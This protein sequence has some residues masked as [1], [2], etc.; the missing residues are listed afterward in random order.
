MEFVKDCPL[1]G[2]GEGAA[3][4]LSCKDHLMGKGQYSL[5]QC[6]NCGLV[7]TNPR[8]REEDLP[9]F[10]QSEEYLS[11]SEKKKSL[12]QR[13]YFLVQTLMLNRKQQLI[14]NLTFKGKRLLDIGCGAGAF[15]KHMQNVGY[16]VVGMEPQATAREKSREKGIQVFESQEEILKKGNLSFD[17][18]TLWH[19]LEHQPNFMEGLDQYH[20]LLD[21]QGYLIIAIPQYES[22]DARHYRQWWAAYD[23]PR[24]LFHFSQKTLEEAARQKGFVLVEKMGMP[25]DAFYVSMLSEKYQGHFLGSFRGAMVGLWSNLLACL[26]IHPWSSQ[27]FVF[28]K[29]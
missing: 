7:Y 1:C 3:P 13:L 16:Q 24:H 25:F 19:V 11:H 15:G 22:F 27:I 21:D 12:G 10:Y 26:K 6:G 8:P 28:R 29:A 4:F 18:I 5:V 14:R 17:F 2:A 20:R 9:F 23:L